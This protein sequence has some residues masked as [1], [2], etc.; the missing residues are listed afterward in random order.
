M[1]HN[2]QKSKKSKNQQAKGSQ[3][4]QAAPWHRIGN[5]LR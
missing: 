2:Q 3:K 5:H 4:Q 1:A